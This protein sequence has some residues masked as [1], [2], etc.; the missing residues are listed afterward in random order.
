ME[1][2]RREFTMSTFRPLFIVLTIILL[3]L[4]FVVVVIVVFIHICI[5]DFLASQQ[6][7]NILIP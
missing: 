4:V 6:W 5:L 3:L 1:C 2:Y 7:V